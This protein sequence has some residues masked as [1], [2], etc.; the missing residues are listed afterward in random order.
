MY[1]MTDY[2]STLKGKLTGGTCLRIGH[3]LIATTR[4]ASLGLLLGDI[5]KRTQAARAGK[6]GGL[7][8]QMYSAVSLPQIV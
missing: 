6:L 2:N 3:S 5:I 8:V 1:K 7:K 4:I